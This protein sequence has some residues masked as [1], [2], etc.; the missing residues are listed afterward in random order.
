MIGRPGSFRRIAAR[1]RSTTC[2]KLDG[3]LEGEVA[4]NSP[5]YANGRMYAPEGPGLGIELNEL[6]IAEHITRG[7]STRVIT[8]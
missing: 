2:S 5:R 8:A 4:L 1:C 7:Y 3:E 6:F